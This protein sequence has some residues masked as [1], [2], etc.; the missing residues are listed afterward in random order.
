MWILIAF[1]VAALFAGFDADW[2]FMR[3]DASHAVFVLTLAYWVYALSRALFV[4]R[5]AVRS[6]ARV[7]TLV[8]TGIYARVRHPI[9]GA[10]IALVWG[11]WLMFP[12]VRML[13]AAG[14]AT[15]VFFVWARIEEDFLAKRF[16]V[17]Y[18]GYRARVPMLFPR[19]FGGDTVSVRKAKRAPRKVVVVS[20]EPSL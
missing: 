7:K 18:L 12:S 8:K 20:R 16:K 4:N 11:I 5:S 2:L 13:L 14:W 6:V 9:Y 3:A 10:D 17:A 19:C 15:L 1:G